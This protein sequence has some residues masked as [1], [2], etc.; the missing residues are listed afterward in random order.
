MKLEEGCGFETTDYLECLQILDIL[1]MAGGSA[2]KLEIGY[3]VP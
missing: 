2:L 1:Y 3:C